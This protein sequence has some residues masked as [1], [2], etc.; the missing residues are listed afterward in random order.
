MVLVLCYYISYINS[1]AII[2]IAKGFMKKIITFWQI[3]RFGRI[4]RY[5]T[6]KWVNDVLRG[7]ILTDNAMEGFRSIGY[8]F[9]QVLPPQ[10]E[11]GKRE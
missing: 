11:K 10:E 9:K 3:V 2:V 6:D 4:D 7:G 1:V 5:S 8:T